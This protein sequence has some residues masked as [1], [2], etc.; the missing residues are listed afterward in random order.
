[1]LMIELEFLVGY[2]GEGVKKGGKLEFLSGD[3]NISQYHWLFLASNLLKR[4]PRG[5]KLD[6]FS[7][8]S[9]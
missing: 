1:M 3:R 2:I 6:L 5:H 4:R 7:Q 8:I 9:G